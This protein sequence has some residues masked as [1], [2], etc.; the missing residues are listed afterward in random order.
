MSTTTSRLEL[1][2]VIEGE[3]HDADGGFGIVAVHVENGRLHHA[4]DVGA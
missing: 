4:R 3:A 2:P 1:L